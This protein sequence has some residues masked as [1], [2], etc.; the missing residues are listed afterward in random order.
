MQNAW[1]YRVKSTFGLSAGVRKTGENRGPVIAWG[2]RGPEFKSRR[3]DQYLQAFRK[4]SVATSVA[5]FKTSLLQPSNLVPEGHTSGKPRTVPEV[6]FRDHRRSR[7]RASSQLWMSACGQPTTRSLIA[8]GQGKSDCRRRR[9]KVGLLILSQRQM[10][11]IRRSGAAGIGVSSVR[12]GRCTVAVMGE[13]RALRVCMLAQALSTQNEA[14]RVR[15]R[16]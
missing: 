10:S 14:F 5:T 7:R 15:S 1:D 8:I 13:P 4:V 12:R 16:R 3:P 6:P 2:A 11:A 9:Q